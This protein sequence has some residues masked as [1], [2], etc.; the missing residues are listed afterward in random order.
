MAKPEAR[1][2]ARPLHWSSP[3]CPVAG[4]KGEK[5]LF[6]MLRE[7]ER[8]AAG[9]PCRASM[10]SGGLELFHRGST[11]Q[12]GRGA[13]GRW[14]GLA[15]WGSRGWERFGPCAFRG[16]YRELKGEGRKPVL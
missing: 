13:C 10:Q 6:L 4:R 5:G 15:G 16:C 7:D 11:Q 3:L 12:G 9:R 1:W 2:V 8:A 14:V